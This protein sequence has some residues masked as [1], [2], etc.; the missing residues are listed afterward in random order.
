MSLIN[1]YFLF[2]SD[3]ANSNTNVTTT[4]TTTLLTC[5]YLLAKNKAKLYN[6]R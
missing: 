2:I 3:N 1:I 4:T 5:S 6:T